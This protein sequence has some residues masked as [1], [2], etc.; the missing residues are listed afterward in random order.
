MSSSSAKFAFPPFYNLPPSFTLQPI[1]NTKKKQTQLWGDLILSYARYN[2]I[3]EMN[4]IESSKSPLFCNEKINRKLSL[5]AI[6]TFVDALVQQGFGE[7]QDK[8][9]TKVLLLFRKADEWANMIYSWVVAGGY[10]DTVLTLWEI[11]S[12][13]TANDQ[14]FHGLDFKILL[15]AL[16][17]LEKSGKCQVFS[18]SSGDDNLGVKF[19]TA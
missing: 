9:H 11:Q 2:K 5:E 8:E 14:E 17:V 6:Q 7:W 13:D 15:K 3:Y 19:F 16:R 1:L 12:G 10:L 4:L 18:S